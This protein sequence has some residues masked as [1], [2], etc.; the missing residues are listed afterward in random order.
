MADSF[1]LG[2]VTGALDR[3][4]PVDA[5]DATGL[6]A[7]P[8]SKSWMRFCV[9]ATASASAEPSAW[10]VAVSAEAAPVGLDSLRGVDDAAAGDETPEV[11]AP[12]SVGVVRN[13]VPAAVPLSGSSVPTPSPG[14]GE[15]LP[16][17]GAHPLVP[18]PGPGDGGPGHGGSPLAQGM[19]AIPWLGPLAQGTGGQG[20]GAIPWAR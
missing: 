4:A 20:M 8:T 1:G 13:A 18:S 11:L 2:L 10:S 5:L 14:A 9:A 3:A 19:G 6:P 7:S 12:P 15:A 17:D 16:G